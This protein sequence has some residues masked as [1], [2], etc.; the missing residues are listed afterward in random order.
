M[1]SKRARL[2][3]TAL[4]YY[5]SALRAVLDR[6]GEVAGFVCAATLHALGHAAVAFIAGAM[7][8]SLAGGMTPGGPSASHSSGPQASP[9]AVA[10]TVA[11][12]ATIGMKA[13]AGVYATYVQS[14]IAGDA[15]AALRLELLDALLTVHRLRRPRHACQ[16]GQLAPTA[17]GVSALTDHV[18]EVEAGLGQ[19]LLG[20]ARAIAQLVPLGAL[21]FALSPRMALAAA[22][23][24]GVFG[25]LLSRARVGYRAA[26]ARASREREEASSRRCRR[27]RT[28]R[29]ALGHLRRGGQGARRDARARRL[30]RT[31]LGL[32]GC[33]RRRSQRGQRGAGCSS[34]ASRCSG[35]PR[36][37]ARGNGGGLDA[38]GVR[39]GLLPGVPAHARAGRRASGRDARAA[40]LRGAPGE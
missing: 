36:R 24:Q 34:L 10:L 9:T 16:G 32:A 40:R 11:G 37:L 22:L 18:R 2:P 35:L 19:G 30:D 15:A 38:A 27:V 1:S 8:I 33:S 25:W 4:S 3:T 39:G 5:V 29:R 23:A 31:K 13:A 7:A 26:L 6:P 14:R 20:G 12:L 21:L 17:A 28:S